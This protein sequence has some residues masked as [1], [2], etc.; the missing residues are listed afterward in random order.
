MNK[1]TKNAYRVRNWDKYNQSLVRRGRLTL[2][3]AEDMLSQWRNTESNGQ[4]GAN[5]YYSDLAIECILTLRVVYHLPLRQTEGLACSIMEMMHIELDVPDYTTLCRRAKRLGVRLEPSPSEQARHIVIDS[6]GVKVYGEG[7]WKVRQHG[8]S[9]RRTWRKVHLGVDVATQEII[10]VEMTSNDVGDCEVLPTLLEQID[11]EITA[12]GADGA[13]DT[14]EVYATIQQRGARSV[15][16]PRRGAK[17]WHHGNQKGL[18]H[19]RDENL[20][21]I[22]THGRKHWKQQSEYHQ[23]SLAETAVY[24]FKTIFGEKLSARLFES[25]CTEV[26]LKSRAVNIMTRLGMPESYVLTR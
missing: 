10:A 7:E 12:V 20:R 3:I 16:P 5:D 19:P 9:K 14:A 23:R 26:F 6:T 18:P 25:Q 21:H 22:R 24:R 1:A 2:W 13:Y 11:G 4:R 8:A 17:I 15:I